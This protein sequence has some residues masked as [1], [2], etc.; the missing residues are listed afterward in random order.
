MFQA[1]LEGARFPAALRDR[2]GQLAAET[3][4]AGGGP[5]GLRTIIDDRPG[6]LAPDMFARVDRP[7]LDRMEVIR[8]SGGTGH[9][10]E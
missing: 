1:E 8:L 5:A 4:A 2:A 3:A 6:R 10:A 7:L 9:T